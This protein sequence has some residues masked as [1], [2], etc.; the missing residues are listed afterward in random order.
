M[1]IAPPSH[2]MHPWF[3]GGFNAMHTAHAQGRGVSINVIQ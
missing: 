2:A 1:G 3:K